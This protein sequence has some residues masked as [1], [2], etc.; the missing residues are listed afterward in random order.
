M[1]AAEMLLDLVFPR[2]CPLCDDIISFRFGEGKRRL[3][4]PD[5]RE[6]VRIVRDPYCMRCGRP[7]SGQDA[8]EEKEYCKA[9]R[10]VA[11]AFDRGFTVF[12]YRSVAESL[13]RF[14]YRGR[15]EYADYY[16]AA[17]E[18]KWGKTLRGLGAE[19]LVPVPLHA[20][21]LKKRGY[22]Q[23]EVFAR[24]VSRE[25]GIPLYSD[26]ALRVKDTAPQKGLSREKRR[27]NVK[28]AFIIK[29][30]DVE[31]KCMVILDDIYTTGSTADELAALFKSHG[32][33]RVYVLTVAA[34]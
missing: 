20:G 3:I 4:C 22:N 17:A 34:A 15:R 11:H 30:N 31:L 7:L 5:C 25:T 19:A 9:C 13:Y 26:L 18:R 14:K 32:V 2:R 10:R 1:K 16:A 12:E 29:K 27:F 33:R 23:A 28:N 24:A 8:A 21:K 6:K